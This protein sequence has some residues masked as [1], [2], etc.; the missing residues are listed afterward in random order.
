MFRRPTNII[1]VH[2]QQRRYL[3]NLNFFS[4]RQQ[5]GGSATLSDGWRFPS[6][7]FCLRQHCEQYQFHSGLPKNPHPF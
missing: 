4:N 2:P 7:E 5:A 6:L 3:K 1:F